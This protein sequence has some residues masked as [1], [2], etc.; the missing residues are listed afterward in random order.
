LWHKP[1][2][3]GDDWLAAVAKVPGLHMGLAL[4]SALASYLNLGQLWLA[5]RRQGVYVSQPGW[6]KHLVRLAAACAAMVAVLAIGLRHWPEW[7]D[8]STATRVL[9]LGVLI[10]GGGGTFVAV[11]FACGFRLRDLRAV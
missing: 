2:D 5:L 1:Q 10:A 11:L 7:G 4:A 6:A 3:L 8:W 9:R